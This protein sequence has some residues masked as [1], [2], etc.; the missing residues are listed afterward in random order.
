MVAKI[1]TF[2]QLFL[3]LTSMVSTITRVPHTSCTTTS[4]IQGQ[5]VSPW[6]FNQATIPGQIIKWLDSL[7][8][9]AGGWTVQS[10]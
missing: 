2:L 4:Y 7:G 8:N 5:T 3:V 9:P 6:N 1:K 10:G